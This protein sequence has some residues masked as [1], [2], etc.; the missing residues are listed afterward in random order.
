MVTR[1]RSVR[2]LARL[3]IVA[4]VLV[5]VLG[6]ANIAAGFWL[7]SHHDL[8][9]QEFRL[10]RPAPYAD[11]PYWSPQ[12]VIEGYAPDVDPE[13]FLLPGNYHSQYVNVDDHFRRTTGQPENAEHTVW[14]FGSSTVFD[15]EVPDDLT[16]ASQL[17]GLFNAYGIKYRVINAGTPGSTASVEAAR[18]RTMQFSHGDMMI[19][20]DGV[21]DAEKPYLIAHEQDIA[22]PERALN[23]IGD[24][25][26]R[27]AWLLW[28]YQGV[29]DSVP[30]E[31]SDAAYLKKAV[32]DAAANYCQSIA[33][34][35]RIAA[36]AGVTFYQVL[37]PHLFTRPLSSYEEVLTRNPLLVRPRLDISINA[38][39]PEL[40]CD[41]RVIDL[42]H[43]LDRLRASGVE[44][45]LDQDHMT[46]R[47]NAVIA[48]ALF[49][50]LTTF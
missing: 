12:F 11:S 19:F 38:V 28:I 45:Y 21:T 20:Y 18:L 14:L 33:D 16:V 6:V 8:T 47:G 30:L 39:Y 26:G 3:V 29:D 9:P 4:A 46:E 49:T 44:I 48:E 42:S 37:Q 36:S 27:P 10:A 7:V 13:H 23:S 40:H 31:M 24:H 5:I 25:F 17:Q 41:S 34:A 15:R 43:A 50:A 32:Q 35:R 22:A 2:I 1:R